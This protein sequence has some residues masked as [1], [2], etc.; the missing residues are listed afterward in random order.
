M[1]SSNKVS[2][3]A[4]NEPFI[5]TP[6]G[7]DARVANRRSGVGRPGADLSGVQISTH[8]IGPAGRGPFSPT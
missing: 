6:N 7:H 2:P 4:L 5:Q 8:V 1:R 3:E